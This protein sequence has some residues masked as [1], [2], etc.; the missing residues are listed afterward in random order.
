MAKDRL[1]IVAALLIG[2]GIAFPAGLWLS[3]EPAPERSQPVPADDPGHRRAFSPTVLR[4]P[5]FLAEQRKGIEALERRCREA[6]EFCTEA[7]EG[8]R[9]LAEQ[10]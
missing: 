9:W 4:D 8:R 2:A 7:A 1:K 6:A 10:R 3:G 5:H